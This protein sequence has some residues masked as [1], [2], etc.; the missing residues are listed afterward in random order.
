MSN[1][2]PSIGRMVRRDDPAVQIAGTVERLA[3]IT[4]IGPGWIDTSGRLDFEASGEATIG[5]IEQGSPQRITERVFLDEHGNEVLEAD[6]VVLLDT[7]QVVFPFHP[8]RRHG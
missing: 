1:P 4:T 7:G 3:R 8:W 6:V 2:S 5:W